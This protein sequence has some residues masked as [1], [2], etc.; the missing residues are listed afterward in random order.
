MKGL[1][2]AANETAGWTWRPIDKE[3]Q[4]PNPVCISLRAHGA[5]MLDLVGIN[6]RVY[7]LSISIWKIS[8]DAHASR[9]REMRTF[10]IW[11]SQPPGV[12]PIMLATIKPIST[13]S[14]CFEDDWNLD[15]LGPETHFRLLD[16]CGF[17]C[18][19]AFGLLSS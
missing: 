5:A 7:C 15:K 1:S 12:S 3:T 6:T 11:T 17:C 14:I 4:A 18:Q 19:D 10:Q 16:C 9:Y 8:G 2:V 13:Y